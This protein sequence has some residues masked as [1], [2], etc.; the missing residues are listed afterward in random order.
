MRLRQ[1]WPLVTVHGVVKNAATGEPLPRVLV[2]VESQ[3]GK[4][5]LTDGGWPL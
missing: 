2:S 4:G 1:R 5:V 3:S